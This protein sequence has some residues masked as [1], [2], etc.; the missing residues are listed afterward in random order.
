MRPNNRHCQTQSWCR[1]EQKGT[2]ATIGS[3]PCCTNIQ[4]VQLS[5]LMGPLLLIRGEKELSVI[6]L[7]IIIAIC[8][9]H[10]CLC[11]CHCLCCC[12]CQHC[13]CCCYWPPAFAD[14]FIVGFFIVVRSSLLSSHVVMQPSTLSLPAAFAANHHPPLPPPC[15]HRAVATATATMMV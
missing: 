13:R 6:V 15:Y 2:A 10:R 12:H 8:C 11:R 7:V 3:L 4:Y 1:Q 9:C 14:P 5:P